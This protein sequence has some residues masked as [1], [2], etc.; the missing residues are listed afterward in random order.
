MPRISRTYRQSQ[1]DDLNIQ[2]TDTHSGVRR[3]HFT[4]AKTFT[5]IIILLATPRSE[6]SEY[7]FKTIKIS[8]ERS[9]HACNYV[10]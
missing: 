1:K 3:E 4:K 2:T 8:L 7:I 6:I 9:C 10:Y 5:L